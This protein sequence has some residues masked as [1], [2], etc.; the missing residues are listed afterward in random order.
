M[1]GVVAESGGNVTQAFQPVAWV[2]HRL[3]SL[4]HFFQSCRLTVQIVFPILR[5]LL[6][7]L[8][9]LLSLPLC[10]HAASVVDWLAFSAGADRNHFFLK[11]DNGVIVAQA[12]VQIVLGLF[13]P[14]SPSRQKLAA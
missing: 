7:S 10:S 4:C 13:A 14:L 12:E 5:R 1:R 2:R 11:D 8:A 6:L 9:S 3:E